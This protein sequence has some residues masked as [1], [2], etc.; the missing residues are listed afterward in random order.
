M[1]PNRLIAMFRATL[2]DSAAANGQP[3]AGQQDGLNRA[4]E[5]RCGARTR[6]G[7]PCQR[8]GLGRGGRCPSHGGKSSG[9]TSQEGRAR[10]AR[11]QKQRW[12]KWRAQHE[13]NKRGVSQS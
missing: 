12:R 4:A 11:A 8:K 2:R 13:R 5:R 10:I 6:A 9:A 7:H 1:D 3:Q